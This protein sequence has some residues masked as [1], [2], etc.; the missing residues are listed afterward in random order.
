M[1]AIFVAEQLV[2]LIQVIGSMLVL[3]VIGWLS[4]RADLLAA[5]LKRVLPSLVGKVLIPSLLFYNMLTANLQL[6][7]NPWLL[8]AYF[9]PAL[10]LVL[11][12]CAA[13]TSTDRAERVLC[14]LYSNTLYVGVPVI[15]YVQG[16]Q[17]IPYVLSIILVNTLVVF[18]T[19]TV[20]EHLQ[21]RQFNVIGLLSGVLIS[22]RNPIVI[23]LLLG[24]LLN[25][26]LSPGQ[27]LSVSAK[28]NWGCAVF[29]LAL[30]TL[31]LSMQGIGST[32]WLKLP[33]ALW[34]KLLLF[35]L[36]VWVTSDYLLGL[37]SHITSVL[38]L[39]AAS[40]L[41]VNAYFLLVSQGKDTSAV[42]SLI[43]Q[44]S[45]LSIASISVW[46]L[47]LNLLNGPG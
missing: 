39:L 19:Y 47:L 2:G 6:V 18:S 8:V 17:A 3:V 11:L 16:E 10:V 28:Q 24:L 41:G 27:L 35:P 38:V 7:L 31:G 34:V 26:L 4:N 23:S 29:I 15:V 5:L 43:I 9:L 1:S 36:A 14:S 13:S 12:L 42:G 25:L 45:V 40:P 44:S 33:A 30:F 21:N 20:L 46:V 37:Q 22:C 32:K